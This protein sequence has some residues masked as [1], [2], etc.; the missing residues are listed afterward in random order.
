MGIQA[1]V[2]PGNSREEVANA[3]WHFVADTAIIIYVGV[4]GTTTRDYRTSAGNGGLECPGETR[5]NGTYGRFFF[6]VRTRFAIPPCFS[7]FPLAQGDG[8]A[9]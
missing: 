7:F 5:G 2:R 1:P 8:E 9:D 3:R 4:A 6:R